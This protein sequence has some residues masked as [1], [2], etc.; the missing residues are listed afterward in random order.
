MR[1][2]LR[3]LLTGCL[4]GCLSACGTNNN[5]N[6]QATST[7]TTTTTANTQAS[8]PGVIQPTA[9]ATNEAG[10]PATPGAP[11]SAANEMATTGGIDACS[12]ITKQ[13][14]AKI[15]G[16]AIKETKSNQ[17]NDGEFLMSQCF[18]TAEEFVRSVSLSV[19][20][21][22]PANP[23]RQPKDYFTEKFRDAGKKSDTER[24]KER[25]RERERAKERKAGG[26]N[27]AE[28]EEEEEEGANVERVSGVGDQAYWV[29]S[30]PSA[31]LYVLKKNQFIILSIGGSDAEPLKLKKTKALAQQALKRLK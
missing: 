16:A 18:Y 10:A 7:T 31:L 4:L 3:F 6:P 9:A 26:E 24:E 29:K 5:P 12:L 30:G 25:E 21:A 19:I 23:T 1:L 2:K 11:N 13:E 17:R 27:Q 8:Q 20:Q 15:Q 14:M 22:N 28:R